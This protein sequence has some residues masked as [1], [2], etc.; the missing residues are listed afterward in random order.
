MHIANRRH[1]MPVGIERATIKAILEQM[2]R[3]PRALIEPT[4]VG[5]KQPMHGR[6]HPVLVIRK[7]QM[8]VVAHETPRHNR[9]LDIAA[10]VT[11]QLQ[12]LPPV[13]IALKDQ[14]LARPTS[15][16][17]V[18]AGNGP[19]VARSVELLIEA[20]KLLGLWSCGWSQGVGSGQAVGQFLARLHRL[21]CGYDAVYRRFAAFCR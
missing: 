13:L 11:R 7:H 3:T 9:Y 20:I 14:L 2:A 5:Q 10:A 8:H 6:A 19:P 21:T 12:E 4:R 15:T 1:Q 17:I 18:I 16:N